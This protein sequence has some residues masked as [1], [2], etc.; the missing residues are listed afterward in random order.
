MRENLT[1]YAKL[2]GILKV[3]ERIEQVSDEFRLDELL[4]RKVRK[5]SSGPEDSSFSC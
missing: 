1:V 2:Y 3:K 4:D 5:L